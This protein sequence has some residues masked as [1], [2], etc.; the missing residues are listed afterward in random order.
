MLGVGY[1]VI[2]DVLDARLTIGTVAVIAVAKLGAWWLALGSGTSGGTLAPILL[3]SSSFGLVLGSGLN[4]V[5]PG[6]DVALG[7][8]ALVAMAATFG[9]ATQATFTAIVF[10]FELT[11]DYDVVLPLMLATV[12]ADIVYSAVNDD[13]LMT[14]KLRR[15]GLHIGRHYAADPFASTRV[16]EIMT[17]RVITLPVTATVA[18]ARSRFAHGGHGA[19]PLVDD[20]SHVIGIISRSDV[21]GSDS[22]D[23]EPLLALASTDVVTVQPFDRA[24][25]ALRLMIDESVEHL[26]VVHDGR[27]VG[28][29]TRSDLLKVRRRQLRHEQREPGL[30]LRRW[31]RRS[32]RNRAEHSLDAVEVEALDGGRRAGAGRA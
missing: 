21:L 10:V 31:R 16:E 9:A 6:P 3:I 7:A 29:C 27:L 13:S 19:Y 5:L 17:T 28:I 15:R 20:S 2:G 26:P 14:E 24:Q 12:I 18:L 1:A 8:F 11:R 23:D 4:H 22:A 30:V 25:T 32:G